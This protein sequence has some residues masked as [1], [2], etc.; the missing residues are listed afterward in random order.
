MLF[1]IILLSQRSIFVLCIGE[2]YFS[3]VHIPEMSGKSWQELIRP[4][5]QHK[6][7]LPPQTWTFIPLKELHLNLPSPIKSMLGRISA[8]HPLHKKL[9][10]MLKY[11]LVAALL[12]RAAAQV[13]PHSQWSLDKWTFS[14]INFLQPNV[15][16]LVG[17]ASQSVLPDTFAQH[18]SQNTLNACQLQFQLET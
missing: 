4:H 17:R 8:L 16:E 9:L 13:A 15:A 5:S 18:R 14:R 1:W 10:I 6:S 2:V 11:L 3:Q 12:H 7:P